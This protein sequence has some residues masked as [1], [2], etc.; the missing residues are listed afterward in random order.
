MTADIRFGLRQLCAVGRGELEAEEFK[1]LIDL[2]HDDAGGR[3]AAVYKALEFIRN[4]GLD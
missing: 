3:T 4:G 1:T 2:D